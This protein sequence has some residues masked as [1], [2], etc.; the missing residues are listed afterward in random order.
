[1]WRRSGRKQTPRWSR[2]TRTLLPRPD[3]PAHQTNQTAHRGGFFMGA[4][5]SPHRELLCPHGAL[6]LPEPP[7]L[8]GVAKQ[9]PIQTP[10]RI[11]CKHRIAH[12]LAGLLALATTGTRNTGTPTPGAPVRRP[13]CPPAPA[14]NCPPHQAHPVLAQDRPSASDTRPGASCAFC[15]MAGSCQ[16]ATPVPYGW[17][18]PV[19]QNGLQQ[20]DHHP[21]GR[22]NQAPEL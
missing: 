7:G 13:G 8:H 16:A 1:M 9:H 3:Q 21:V 20:A 2:G 15:R 11:L 17:S 4:S 10:A 18:W 22:I 19:H 12:H 14:N 5:G 6:A